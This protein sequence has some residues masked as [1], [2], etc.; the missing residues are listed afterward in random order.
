M[1]NVMLAYPSLGV[2]AFSKVKDFR[3]AVKGATGSEAVID[4]NFQCT[5]LDNPDVVAVRCYIL[6]KGFDGSAEM[7]AILAH[8]VSHAV[9]DWLARMHEDRPGTEVRAYAMQAAME[10]CLRQLGV[11]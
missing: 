3:R 6:V 10:T 8:E 5:T 9:D 7:V 1:D 2:E 11:E 4:S